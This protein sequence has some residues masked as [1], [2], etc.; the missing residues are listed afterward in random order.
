MIIDKRKLK[1][2]KKVKSNSQV[3]RFL[4]Y[5]LVKKKSEKHYTSLVIQKR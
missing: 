2:T 5:K 1:I 4:M 3:L